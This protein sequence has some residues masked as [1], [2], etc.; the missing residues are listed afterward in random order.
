MVEQDLDLDLDLDKLA[1]KLWE[2]APKAHTFS[3]KQVVAIIVTVFIFASG[4]GI[5]WNK[6]LAFPSLTGEQWKS[7][8]TYSVIE[9]SERENK[10]KEVLSEI[11][12]KNKE[13]DIYISSLRAMAEEMKADTKEIKRSLANIEKEVIKGKVSSADSKS[14]A[15]LERKN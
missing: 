15:K 12:F 6:I 1:E 3:N 5:T 14:I 2:K 13:Q 10:N 7:V 8:Y 4:L 11:N 9:K